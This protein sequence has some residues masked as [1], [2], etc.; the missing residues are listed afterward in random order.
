MYL[1][2]HHTLTPRDSYPVE[3]RYDAPRDTY[4]WRTHA[5]TVINKEMLRHKGSILVFLS[6][7]SDI[8]YLVERLRETAPQHVMI[9]PLY[10]EL[11]LIPHTKGKS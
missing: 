7:T 5:F 1:G 6:G 4:R 2:E 3:L 8:H 11:S 10:G 9:C